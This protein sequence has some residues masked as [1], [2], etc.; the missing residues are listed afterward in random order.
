[1]AAANRT[2][3]TAPLLGL[4]DI[5]ASGSAPTGVSLGAYLK[6][7]LSEGTFDLAFSP[8]TL[9]GDSDLIAIASPD[10]ARAFSLGISDGDLAL[11]FDDGT[12]GATTF[13]VS[14]DLSAGAQHQLSLSFDTSAL[15]VLLDGAEVLALANPAGAGLGESDILTLGDPAGSASTITDLQLYDSALPMDTG[16]IASA[17]GSAAKAASGS[18]PISIDPVFSFM[19]T[20]TYTGS[21]GDFKNVSHKKALEL[22]NGTMSM[23]FSLDARRGDMAL[24]SKDLSGSNDGDFTVWVRDAQLVV[25]MQ[26]A[27]VKEYLRVPNVV[28]QTQT[29]YHLAVTFGKDGLHIYLDGQLVAAEPVFTDGLKMNDNPLVIGATRAW[30][31]SNT[32]D[33]D[34]LF[35]GT[36]SDVMLFDKQLNTNT[37]MALT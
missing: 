15:R 33:P 36:I 5:S 37:V 31:S 34:A 30:D 19:G 21:L 14:A 9:S 27:S 28:L 35:K 29:E 22:D 12:G 13:A 26:G 1:M 25:E 8:A 2:Y 3:L 20:K 6:N 17:R 11:Q 18:S 7:P 23:G 10:G 24:I 32:A 4:D 16:A